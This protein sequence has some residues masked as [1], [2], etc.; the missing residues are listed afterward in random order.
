MNASPPRIFVP[1]DGALPPV[2]A[3][4]SARQAVLGRCLGDMVR[5]AA[6]PHNVVLVGPRG[7]GKTALLNWFRTTCESASRVDV[8][9]LTPGEIADA[10]GLT[11]AV[12]PRR[13]IARLFGMIAGFIGM[14]NNVQP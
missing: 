5:G 4:R 1:G 7:N 12:V 11:D 3:G 10:G 2:L 9:S 6:P 8:V 13:G 14:L